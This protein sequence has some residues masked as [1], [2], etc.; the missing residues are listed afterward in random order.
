MPSATTT[1]PTTSS[2]DENGF[3]TYFD[4]AVEDF[5]KD[6]PLDKD[7]ASAN[8]S[9]AR[10]EDS[11]T[12]DIDEEVRIKRARRPTAKLDDTRLLSSNG[13]P[14]LRKI[15][16]TRLKFR[17]KGHEFTDIANLLSMYQLWLDDLFPK[18]KFRDALGMVEAVGHKKRLQV[19]RK[20]W[21]DETKPFRNNETT[22][23]EEEVRMNGG[24]PGDTGRGADAEA[25]EVGVS[26]VVTAAQPTSTD[27]PDDDELDAL[28]AE[29]TNAT[30]TQKAS[31]PPPKRG[32]FEEEDIDDDELEALL[33]EEPEANTVAKQASAPMSNDKATGRT[34]PRED[35][36][37]DEEDAMAD[38]DL[39]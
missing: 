32:P 35:D 38:M 27:A 24:L 29:N 6:L 37:A 36:F 16:K 33:A 18:A 7:N 31:Q 17:G 1:N 19:M 15:S 5:L 20:A 39:W 11:T 2:Y 21:I 23:E 4:D 8:R 14:R 28:L 9:N 3:T 12:K 30:T 26:G 25:E 34:P 13:I 10:A 22:V